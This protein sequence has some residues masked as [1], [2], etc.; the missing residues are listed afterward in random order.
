MPSLSR[1]AAFGRQYHD[2]ETGLY[3]NR[4]RYYAPDEAMYVSQDPI[5]L[6]GGDRFYG[7]VKDSN[8]WVDVLG[9]SECK[10]N[11]NQLRKS[12]QKTFL[13]EKVERV[14]LEAPIVVYRVHGG[15]AGKIG[16]F[17]SSEKFTSRLSARER[18]AL[19]QEWGNSISKITRVEI[20][21]QTTIWK[22]KAAPQIQ[23]NGKL[24]KGGGDQIWLDE[25]DP[26][27]FKTTYHFK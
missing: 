14:L 13:D 18:L 25:L 3:Y 19:K 7:Y 5:G 12:V 23:N 9:L 1:S 10:V 6:M 26:N 4:F 17:L 8:A 24:L 16:R 22:G 2:V 20:P 27:W 11:S 21:A 15:K